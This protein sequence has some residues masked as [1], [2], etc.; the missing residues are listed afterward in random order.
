[1][2][3]S[4]EGPLAHTSLCLTAAEEA[5]RL[6]RG[7]AGKSTRRLRT[8]H[9]TPP[10]ACTSRRPPERAGLVRL[11]PTARLSCCPRRCPAV[12]RCVSGPHSSRDDMRLDR[13]ASWRLTPVCHRST[14]P[15]LLSKF[16]EQL[17]RARF[18]ITTRRSRVV[19]YCLIG[20]RLMD[21]PAGAPRGIPGRPAARSSDDPTVKP[22][23]S[24][25]RSVAIA[26]RQHATDQ[27]MSVSA[28]VEHL[29]LSEEVDKYGRPRWAAARPRPKRLPARS[30]E[31]PTQ[32]MQVTLSRSVHLTGL[33]Y[34]AR[35]GMTFSGYIEARIRREH[36]RCT[37]QQSPA[38]GKTA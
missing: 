24:M 34:A 16:I 32:V 23:L 3:T 25:A 28:F 7:R 10:A 33:V 13:S 9:V 4:V 20:S 8:A 21:M 26:A 18:L 12:R 37:V 36:D 5:A 35:A 29:I 2:P 31:D 15:R 38:L 19:D 1:M 14:G 17:L 27:R 30:S 6:V 11:R 22:R